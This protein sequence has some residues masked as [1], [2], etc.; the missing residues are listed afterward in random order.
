MIILSRINFCYQLCAYQIGINVLFI[1]Y[2]MCSVLNVESSI[3]LEDVMLLLLP[4][5]LPKQ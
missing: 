3:I 2:S 5:N 4:N 1:L